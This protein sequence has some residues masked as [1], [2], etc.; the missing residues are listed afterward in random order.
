MCSAVGQLVIALVYTKSVQN[1]LIQIDVGNIS[2]NSVN[3]GN[4]TITQV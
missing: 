2:V 3:L 1:V 4:I